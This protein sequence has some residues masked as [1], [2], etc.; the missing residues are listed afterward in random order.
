MKTPIKIKKRDEKKV[1]CDTEISTARTNAQRTTEVIVKNWIVE[2]RE[3]RRLALNHLQ[4]AFRR[5]GI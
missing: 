1:V 4:D 2:L 3:R 5:K